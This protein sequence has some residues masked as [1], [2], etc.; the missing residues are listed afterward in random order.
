ML[1]LRYMSSFDGVVPVFCLHQAVGEKEGKVTKQHISQ[2][3]WGMALGTG[4]QEIEGQEPS[5]PAARIP[6]SLASPMLL[7]SCPWI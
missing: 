7:P 5:V 1:W 6:F 3:A 4:H 2:Y